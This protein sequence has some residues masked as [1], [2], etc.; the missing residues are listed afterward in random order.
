M[1][2]ESFIVTDVVICNELERVIVPDTP[3][4]MSVTVESARPARRLPAPLSASVV[5]V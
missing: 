1:P 2:T 5:T 4:Q 3:K